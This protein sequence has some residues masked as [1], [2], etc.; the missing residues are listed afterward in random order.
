MTVL[1]Q[2]P[3]GCPIPVIYWD[4]GGM[5]MEYRIVKKK[6]MF[7]HHLANLDDSSLAKQVYDVQ[8]KLG[9]P[10]LIKECEQYLVKF[11]VIDIT[12]YTKIQWKNLV[13]QNIAKMNRECLLDKMKSYSKLDQNKFAEEKLG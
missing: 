1:L 9:L 2:V 13:N 4:C 6:L 5:L 8:L 7:L 3:T 11:G 12:K 10:G